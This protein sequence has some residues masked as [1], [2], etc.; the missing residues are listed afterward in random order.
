MTTKK[1]LG[2][3]PAAE[4]AKILRHLE[5]TAA[6]QVDTR[7]QVKPMTTAMAH[8]LLKI[9]ETKVDAMILSILVAFLAGQRISDILQL[10]KNDITSEGSHLV[11]AIRRGKVVPMIGPYTIALSK[12]SYVA[13]ALLS[14]AA[15]RDGFLFSENNSDRERLDL[16]AL[17]RKTVMQIDPGL[18]G[19]SIRKGGLQAMAL[20]GEPL[21]NILLVSKHTSTNMLMRYLE[22]GAKATDH[23]NTIRKLT[24]QSFAQVK[25]TEDGCTSM[26]ARKPNRKH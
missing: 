11:I 2:E 21:Q 15:V 5:A 16:Q 4:D 7:R 20:R 8:S 22:W 26:Q 14:L 10:A 3:A 9:H 19:K 6:T 13:Q 25:E 17:V 18:E 1:L 23:L 24:D 12:S